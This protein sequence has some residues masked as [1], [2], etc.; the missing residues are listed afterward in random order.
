MGCGTGVLGAGATFTATITFNRAISST[1]P[2]YTNFKSALF[3]LLRGLETRGR[4]DDIVEVPGGTG[5][6]NIIQLNVTMRGPLAD[7]APFNR[8]LNRLLW[9]VRH[10]LHDGNVERPGTGSNIT[11]T[12]DPDNWNDEDT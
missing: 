12:A 1:D 10:R 2:C 8:A 11:V 9:G 3:W 7:P 6:R 4:M 5:P